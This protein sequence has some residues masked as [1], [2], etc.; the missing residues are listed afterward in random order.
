[1]PN[2]Q[3]SLQPVPFTQVQLTDGFWAPRQETNRRVTLQHIHRKLQE[4]GRIAAF[5]LNFTRKV[6]SPIVEIFGDSDVAKWIEAVSYSLATHPDPQLAQTLDGV[7]DKVIAAQ[8]PDGYLNTHFIVVQPEMRWKNLRDW[9]EMYCAGHLMEGAVAHAQ[10][11]GQRKLLDALARYADHIDATFGPEPGKK[12]GYCGHPE[13]ELALVRLYHATGNPRYLKLATFFVDE[14][15]QQPHYF[16]IEAR[17]RGED[18]ASFWAKTYEYCQAHVPIRQQDKVVGH[19]VRAMYLFSAVADLAHENNDP[20]LRETCDR[21]W[22][23]LIHRRMYITGGIGPSRHNEGFTEDYDLPDETAY[24]E[25]CATIGLIFWNHRLLQFEGDRRFADVMERGLYNG[26]LSGVTLSGDRFLYENP[27][28]TNG[29]RHHEEW[30]YCPC[31]PPNVARLLASVGGYFYSTGAE[32]VWVH[33]F[34]SNHASLEVAGTALTLREETQYPWDGKVT[35]QMELERPATFTLHLRVPEWCPGYRLS[36]NGKALQVQPGPDGYLAVR[37][38]WQSGDTVVYEMD[39]PVQLIWSN[40][41]V[42]QLEGRV[43]IQRGPVVYCLESVDN[44]TTP[45]DRIS[46]DPEG[47]LKACTV[48]YRPDLLGGVAVIHGPGRAIEAEGWGE[49]LYRPEA[50]GEKEITLT[51]VPYCTWDNREPGEMRVWLRA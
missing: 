14:R 21:L 30:F 11:T 24:A 45:L 8:Q 17:E 19:A 50:P 44:P 16:D 7:V 31:C 1:M 37:R 46:I 41:A 48:E 33:L 43:A 34:A 9:H 42:R 39:M 6:P 40:P 47:F 51:A 12:R 28:S 35:L 26:F 10:A 15:G 32:D 27:L 20:S 13:I 49:V 36:V 38:E 18:P 5:D 3:R 25:T 4:T 2:V 29:S 23:N 22:D